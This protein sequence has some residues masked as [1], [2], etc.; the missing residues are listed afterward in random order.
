MIEIEPS[1]ILYWKN[2]EFKT[3]KRKGKPRIFRTEE[4]VAEWYRRNRSRVDGL[5]V[6]KPIVDGKQQLL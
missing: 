3:A 2:D 1:H 6:V 5:S 4:E